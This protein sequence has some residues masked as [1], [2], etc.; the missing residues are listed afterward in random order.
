LPRTLLG[1]ICDTFGLE[2]SSAPNAVIR[3]N[4]RWN[5]SRVHGV[6]VRPWDGAHLPN[7]EV[8]VLGPGGRQGSE[9]RGCPGRLSEVRAT[10]W[11]S[12]EPGD[13]TALLVQRDVR[14][15]NTSPHSLSR[16]PWVLCSRD[17]TADVTTRS[18]RLSLVSSGAQSSVTASWPNWRPR[19]SSLSRCHPGNR[20]RPTVDLGE[21]FPP[22]L[23]SAR[24]VC[25]Q[26][27]CGGL[28]AFD[29]SDF[30]KPVSIFELTDR[31][32]LVSTSTPEEW[33]IP[34]ASFVG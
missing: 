8:L 9:R 7:D 26:T 3:R 16:L 25:S 1:N 22:R 13:V 6:P 31:W 34:T 20:D 21:P 10:S 4:C 5:L 32:R 29:W 15:A 23:C 12:V 18:A 11:R 24:A 19:T 28:D 17:R 14:K 27:W 33:T 30:T 2:A